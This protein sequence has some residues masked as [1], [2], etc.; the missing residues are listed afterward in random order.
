MAELRVKC[1]SCKARNVLV[2]DGLGGHEMVECSSCHKP[3]GTWAELQMRT[4]TGLA[5]KNSEQVVEKHS[6]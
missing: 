6:A 1:P 3:I 5:A 4:S 2:A